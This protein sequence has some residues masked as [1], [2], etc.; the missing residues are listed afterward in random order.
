MVE[1]QIRLR[2][3]ADAAVLQAMERVP[4]H[5]FVSSEYEYQAYDDHPLPIGYGQTISQPYIV[6]LMT[7]MLRLGPGDR[8]LEIGTGC[9]YQTAVLAEIVGEVYTVE[10]IPEL[11]EEASRRL[12]QLGYERVHVRRGD[13]Y[14]GWPEHAPYNGIIVTAAAPEIPSP[15]LEQLADLG[16]LVIPVGGR[17]EGQD[18]WLLE[19]RGARIERR[20]YGGVLFVPLVKGRKTEAGNQRAEE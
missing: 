7:E 12:Y 9:G 15:L 20:N 4:R 17:F 2:G 19:K 3:V 14:E 8:V 16:R 11:A 13:G 10:V 18:L 5:R 1:T 6:A